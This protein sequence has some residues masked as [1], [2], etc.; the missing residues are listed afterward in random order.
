MSRRLGVAPDV[1]PASITVLYATS[2]ES[3]L[4]PSDCVNRLDTSQLLPRLQ[5]AYRS[6]HSTETALVKVL[7][8][9]LLAIDTGDLAALVLLDLFAAFD[10]IDHAIL[11]RRLETFGLGGTAL[12]WFESYLVGR[13]QHVRTR[14]QVFISD[15]HWVPSTTG[16]CSWPHPLSLIHR[17]FAVVD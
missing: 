9:I 7:S 17:R 3:D 10:T 12:H 14:T 6:K 11:L 13:R 8:D 2:Q 15:R 1:N 16:L 5:S 4:D